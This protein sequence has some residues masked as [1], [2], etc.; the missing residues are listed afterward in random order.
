MTKTRNGPNG[1]SATQNTF[2]PMTNGRD[3]LGNTWTTK[4]AW[5]SLTDNS[6][7]AWR[8]A[9][10]PEEVRRAAFHCLP[11]R[12][13]QVFRPAIAGA[14]VGTAPDRVTV[15]YAGAPNR[16]YEK[17]N[18]LFASC[19]AGAFIRITTNDH[20]RSETLASCA[21]LNRPGFGSV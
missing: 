2:G 20:R 3:S 19:R 14:S 6:V 5:Q 18:V 12:G 17:W 10:A 11:D 1:Y 4:L 9:R 8:N 16:G 15:G 21:G 7:P 13:R